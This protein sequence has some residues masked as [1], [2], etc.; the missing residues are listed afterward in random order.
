LKETE[1]IS[2]RAKE[3]TPEM[4]LEVVLGGRGLSMIGTMAVCGSSTWNPAIGVEPVVEW[5]SCAV[6][7]VTG[8]SAVGI[9]L[10]Y[11]SL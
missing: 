1:T 5:V 4:Y 6:W 2:V 11:N 9:I 8:K 10:A 7:C 3:G